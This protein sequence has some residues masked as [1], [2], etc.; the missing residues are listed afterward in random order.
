ML[1]KENKIS[2]LEKDLTN[3]KNELRERE[4]DRT[5]CKTELGEREKR[6][7]AAQQAQV[8][9]ITISLEGNLAVTCR[10]RTTPPVNLLILSLY[11]FIRRLWSQ[12]LRS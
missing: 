7:D 4:K 12:T 2:L 9:M 3:C 8:E 1:E 6:L 5:K 11:F 10:M